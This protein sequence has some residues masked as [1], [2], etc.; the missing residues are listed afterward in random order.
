MAGTAYFC[1]RF[2]PPPNGATIHPTMKK[3]I[4]FTLAL[5][6]ALAVPGFA[7]KFG[8]CNSNALLAEL[9]EMKQADSELQAFQAQLTKKGQQMVKDW[10]DRATELA[11]KKEQGTISPKE[12]ETQSA[13]LEEEQGKLQELEQDMYKQIGTKREEIYKPIID[14]VN[15]AMQ[16]VAKENGF[17]YVFD[18]SAQFLLY[19][20]ESMD[21]SKLIKA[22][23]GIN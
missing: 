20:D 18:S 2:L 9:P 1:A 8:Y 14:R 16:D 19:A 22:R 10:Q 13:K 12:F 3:T 4:F 11:R 23:L 15:K 6:L 17:A 5:L 21:V 7:Q